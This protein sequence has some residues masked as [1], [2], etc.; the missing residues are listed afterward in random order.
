MGTL[1]CGN[2]GQSTPELISNGIC[3]NKLPGKTDEQLLENCP[4]TSI[5]AIN[6]VNDNTSDPYWILDESSI[7]I[8]KD[9]TNLPLTQFRVDNGIPCVNTNS[10][11]SYNVVG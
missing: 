10:A 8:G 11:L 2:Y 6:F 5:N 3:I 7:S 4:I 9:P 1:P